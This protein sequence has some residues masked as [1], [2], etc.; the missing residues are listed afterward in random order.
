MFQPV[1][2]PNV[3]NAACNW[4][5]LPKKNFPLIFHGVEGVDEREGNSPRY[6]NISSFFQIQA[7][8]SSHFQND[9]IALELE[10]D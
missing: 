5:E 3:I 9:Q 6:E 10:R 2:D 4:R 1:G 7:I 8:G